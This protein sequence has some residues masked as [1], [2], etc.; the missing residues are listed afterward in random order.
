ME[1]AGSDGIDDHSKYKSRNMRKTKHFPVE[2]AFVP[3]FHLSFTFAREINAYD[4]MRHV[5]CDIWR[6]RGAMGLMPI[7]N[8]RVETGEK[9][10]ISRPESR[11]FQVFIQDLHSHFG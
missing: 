4:S 7:R 9:R 5:V 8:T 11:L 3:R 6:A 10:N 1:S 2:I